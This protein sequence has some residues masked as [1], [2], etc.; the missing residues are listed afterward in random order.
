[1]FSKREFTLEAMDLNEATREVVPLSLSDLQ[2]NRV[3]LELELAEPLPPAEVDDRPR[4]LVVRTEWE[5]GAAVRVTVRDAGTGL[6]DQ[7][8]DRLSTPSIRPSRAAWASGSPSVARSS[9]ATTTPSG[10]SL[11]TGRAPPSHSPC[12]G[13][14]DRS[15]RTRTARVSRTT[16]A[17][18]V[19]VSYTHLRAHET[20]EHL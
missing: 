5:G 17:A 13:R 20:P 15:A 11:T 9:S 2:R 18:R 12:R 4:Q 19:A 3:V 14:A 7:S 6:D 1:M 16:R 10:P 8:L